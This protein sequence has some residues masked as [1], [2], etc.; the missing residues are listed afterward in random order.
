VTE[1]NEAAAI[2]RTLPVLESQRLAR[3]EIV[4]EPRNGEMLDVATS[5][6]EQVK[7]SARVP[8][9]ADHCEA[10]SSACS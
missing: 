10:F 1:P 5:F 2:V 6:V 4:S 9:E 7:V 3:P 8:H